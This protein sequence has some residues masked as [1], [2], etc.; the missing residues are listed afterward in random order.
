[1]RVCC[2]QTLSHL[3]AKTRFIPYTALGFGISG[4]ADWAQKW[5]QSRSEEGLLTEEFVLFSKE[6]ILA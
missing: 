2:M 5:L 6:G 4:I 1:M 3:D